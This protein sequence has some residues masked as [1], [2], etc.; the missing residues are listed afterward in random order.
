MVILIPA[1]FD[2]F[3]WLGPRLKLDVLLQPIL[4]ELLALPTSQQ[5]SLPMDPQSIADIW[6]QFNLF[7]ALRTFPIGVFSLMS[8]NISGQTPFGNRMDIELVNWFQAVLLL[9]ALTVLGWILGSMYFHMVARVALKPDAS[10]SPGL[11]HSMF[12]GTLLSGGW[13]II[14]IIVSIP[15]M[16]FFSLMYLIS[17]TVA[18][19]AYL[20][21]L[22]VVIWLAV[23]VFFSGHGIFANTNNAFISAWHTL[24]MIRYGMPPLGWF[25]FVAVIISQGLD[26]LWRV[27]PADSWM[28]LVGILGHAF[29]STSLL[30][31]SFIYYR[32]LN[33]W[34]E[35]ALQWL[36]T[37]TTSARA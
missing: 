27:P 37:Q 28:M 25:S 11:W 29:V 36:K 6:K 5:Q 35:S 26:I 17:P 2:L 34:I 20:L 1:L 15:L 9:L 30:A 23:P 21:L 19:I 13:T 7:S 31:A 4:K 22:L 14:F 8:V 33:S 3:L 16:L 24:R 12:H 18:V 32:D 10:A